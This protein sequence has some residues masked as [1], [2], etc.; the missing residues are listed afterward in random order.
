MFK[1]VD[2]PLCAGSGAVAIYECAGCDGKGRVTP[3]ESRLLNALQNAIKQKQLI[4][5][6]T[7]EECARAAKEWA[8]E[9]VELDSMEEALD[10]ADAL[11]G[12]VWSAIFGGAYATGSE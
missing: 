8:A 1:K 9:N 4:A 3:R 6:Y 11:S 7:A 12:E 10:F 5:Y 2:C